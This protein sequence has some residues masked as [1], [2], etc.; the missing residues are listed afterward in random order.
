MNKMLTLRSLKDASTWTRSPDLE[1]SLSMRAVQESHQKLDDTL[2]K[3]GCSLEGLTEQ[4]AADRLAT[5]GPNEVA[6]EKPPHWLVQLL[7]CFKNPFI[8]VLVA[9]ALI[10]FATSPD[11]LRPVIILG[12][13]V[14]F[15]G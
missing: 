6:H 13:M 7:M 5:D 4:D 8:V 3:L 10:Q 1:K 15:G 2:A 11:D 9:L 12:G 14:G